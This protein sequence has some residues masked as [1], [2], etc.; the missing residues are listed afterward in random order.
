M[1]NPAPVEGYRHFIKSLLA[2]G[3]SPKDIEIMAKRNPA[4]LL[5]V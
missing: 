5:G 1:Y 4:Q 3:I 2:G